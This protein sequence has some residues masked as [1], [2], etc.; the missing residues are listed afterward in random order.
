[1]DPNDYWYRKLELALLQYVSSLEMSIVSKNKSQ[2][3]EE[4]GR[5]NRSILVNSTYPK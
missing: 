4:Y 3:L 2:W 1:M 5:K